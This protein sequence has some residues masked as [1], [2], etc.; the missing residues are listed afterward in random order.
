M[1]TRERHAVDFDEHIPTNTLVI[2][3]AIICSALVVPQ[4]AGELCVRRS[5][6]SSGTHS[7]L[8]PSEQVSFFA[9]ISLSFVRLNGL[10]HPCGGVAS[11]K[12]SRSDPVSALLA[13][14][15]SSAGN[16][17]TSPAAPRHS[18]SF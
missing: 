2:L 17:P 11:I 7:L 8:G 14:T 10:T 4:A 12:L 13:D 9:T 1:T 5:V 6:T 16:A 15:G 18:H 3:C